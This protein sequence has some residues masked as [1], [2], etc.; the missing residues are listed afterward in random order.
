MNEARSDENPGQ[1]PKSFRE[2]VR[3]LKE[4]VGEDYRQAG[5]RQKLGLLATAG[6]LAYEWGPGNETFTPIIA[7]Q[8]MSRTEDAK[9]ALAVGVITGGFTAAQQIV[10]GYAMAS[11]SET[12]GGLAEKSYELAASDENGEATRKPFEDLSMPT[13]AG[14]SLFLGSS[15]VVAREAAVTG[16]TEQSHLRRQAV[17]SA[18]IS[19]PTVGVVTAGA[20]GGLDT[21]S[22]A[23]ENSRFE[24]STELFINGVEHPATWVSL[25]GLALVSGHLRN[26]SKNRQTVPKS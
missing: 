4:S 14:Y 22:N 7:T 10:S 20:S 3:I 9:G 18:A 6:L 21:L 1:E 25:A 23:A 12:F 5:V 8:V 26:R 13:K 17:K 19:A 24:N 16:S 11:S 2:K 15:F